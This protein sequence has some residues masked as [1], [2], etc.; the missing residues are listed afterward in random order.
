MNNTTYT[1]G[2]QLTKVLKIELQNLYLDRVNNYLT[3][4]KFAEYKELTLLEAKVL[5]KL[6]SKIHNNEVENLIKRNN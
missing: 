4:E 5:L 2:I 3:I 6:A 1:A